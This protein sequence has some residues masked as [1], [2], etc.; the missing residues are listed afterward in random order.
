MLNHIYAL[1]LLLNEN[2]TQFQPDRD[3]VMGWESSTVA[4]D[5]AVEAGHTAHDRSDRWGDSA[6]FCDTLCCRSIRLDYKT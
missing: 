4:S 2:F 1:S 5:S 6:N 3:H